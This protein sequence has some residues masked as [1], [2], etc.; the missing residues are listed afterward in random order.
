MMDV[1]QTIE[2][3]KSVRKY[4]DEPIPK[5]KLQM[6][7]NAGRKAPSAGNR[8]PWRF[9]IVQ[10]AERKNKLAVAANNQAFLSH[11]AM[12]IV[13]SA[14]PE[15]SPKW[16]ERDTMIAVEHMALAS[17]AL[18]YGSCWIGAFDEE[19]VKRLLKIPEGIKVVALLPVGVPNETPATRPRKELKEIFSEEEW[20]KP[21]SS[22]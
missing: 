5:D 4:L 20:E 14:N 6:I 17:A 1:F 3:R 2:A 13:A 15:A 7:L 11:A 21:Y 12:I 22:F 8:Q 19:A 10:D 16:C 18:G 9:I